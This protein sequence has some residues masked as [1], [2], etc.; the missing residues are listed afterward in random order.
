[1]AT[2]ESSGATLTV[3]QAARATGLSPKALRRRIERGSLGSTLVDG[4]RRIPMSDLLRAGLLVPYESSG[5]VD[6]R[7]V[8]RA[9]RVGRGRTVTDAADLRA[10]RERITTLE[11]ELASERATQRG[12]ASELAA[13]R[14][15]G[16]ALERRLE[17]L[18]A[19][20]GASG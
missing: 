16:D 20:Q 14:E 12:L 3:K 2:A 15:R 9:G 11:D 5:G 10:L 6:E 4:L 8:A 17:R 1:V 13:E 18:E 19:G 7:A